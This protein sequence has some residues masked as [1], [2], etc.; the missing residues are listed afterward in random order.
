MASPPPWYEPF[1]RTGYALL[2]WI[3]HIIILVSILGGIRLVELIVHHLWGGHDRLFFKKLPQSYVFD[4]AD[5]AVLIGF[6]AYGTY[7]VVAAYVRKD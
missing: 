6:L 1:K 2:E 7:S 3:A 4:G 5:L